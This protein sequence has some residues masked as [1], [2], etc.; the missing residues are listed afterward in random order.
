[1]QGNSELAM[2]AMGALLKYFNPESDQ[3]T[4]DLTTLVQSHLLDGATP[5]RKYAYRVLKWLMELH[6]KRFPKLFPLALKFSMICLSQQDYEELDHFIAQTNYNYNFMND[7]RWSFFLNSYKRRDGVRKSS[8][9]EEETLSVGTQMRKTNQYVILQDVDERLAREDANSAWEL[10]EEYKY[11][12]YRE[13]IEIRY[14]LIDLALSLHKKIELEYLMST[15]RLDP[16][17][18][19]LLGKCL[20]LAGQPEDRAQMILVYLEKNRGNA[21]HWA[22]LVDELRASDVPLPELLFDTSRNC[23]IDIDYILELHYGKR[24]EEDLA[25]LKSNPPVL[26][27]RR[28]RKGNILQSKRSVAEL[29]LQDAELLSHISDRIDSLLQSLLNGS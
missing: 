8:E 23:P 24:L 17:N 16:F 29:L 7:T 13:S 19:E 12:S 5:R 3:I 25:A 10:L 9:A 27:K 26:V 21:D 2:R 4:E 28:R 15:M 11:W 1:M 22:M 14:K 20:K 6:K 18:E